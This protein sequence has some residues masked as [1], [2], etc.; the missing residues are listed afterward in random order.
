ML[1]YG[2]RGLVRQGTL[3]AVTIVRHHVASG[4][5]TG[6]LSDHAIYQVTVLL[7]C[8]VEGIL[9]FLREL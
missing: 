8:L 7:K 6:Q 9:S 5:L 4:E 2:Y 1:G 3:C